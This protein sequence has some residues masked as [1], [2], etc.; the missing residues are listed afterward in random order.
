MEIR[1]GR[2]L[3]RPWLDE[4]FQSFAALNGDSRVMEFFPAVLDRD[5][6]NALTKEIQRRIDEQGWGFWA[7]EIPGEARFIGFTGLNKLGKDLP[8]APG[9]E[10]GW[11]LARDFWGKGYASEAAQAALQ[12]GFRELGLQ[13][14][15]AFTAIQNLRSRAVMSRIGMVFEG[16]I[17]EHPGIAPGHPLRKHVLYRKQNPLTASLSR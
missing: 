15:V 7:V 2:L 13:E 5:Q 8:F 17:F 11:R 14:I 1:T 16:E 12:T 9:V 3:L 4:D 10:I 6:S